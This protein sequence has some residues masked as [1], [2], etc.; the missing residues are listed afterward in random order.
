M[1]VLI[2]DKP[3]V[4]GA[5]LPYEDGIPLESNWHLDAMHLLIRILRHYWRERHDI[6]VGGNM[7]VYFDPEQ[8]KKRNFR[9]PDF[10]VVKGVKDNNHRNSW[11]IW[12]EDYLSPDF[13][14]ELASKSTA[15][16]DV[17]GKKDIYEQQLQTPEYVV[18]NPETDE[19][20]GWRL[21][22]GRYGPIAPNEQ[23]WLWCNELGLWLG[24]T[25]YTFVKGNES[26]KTLRFF[27]EQGQVLP[28][29]VETK[30]QQTVVEAVS[31]QLAEQRAEYEAQRAEAEAKARQ[32]AEQRAEAEAQ[33]AEAAEA[34]IAHL[35][36]L[37]AGKGDP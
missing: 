23:G 19:L 1:A 25:E 29:E 18:Y 20:K 33:R 11:V 37:L 9:G 4:R 24:V 26:A 32:L 21:A 7:F 12:E 22:G 34:E 2:M 3:K 17:T 14:I 28:T 6:Y 15:D 8:S 16:F 5:D 31:R 36:A 30:D 27:D 35:K 10:F 13:V